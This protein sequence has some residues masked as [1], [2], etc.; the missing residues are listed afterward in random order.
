MF[1]PG[2]RLV[3]G[4]SGGADSV[5]LLY[6]LHTLARRWALRLVVAHLHHGIRGQAADDDAS[7]VQQL[8][9]RLGLPC[10]VEYADVPSRSR[11]ARESI[12]MAARAERRAFFARVCGAY[13]AEAVALAHTADDAAETLLL[14]LLRGS[15]LAGLGGLAAESRVGPVRVVR[16]LIDV[17]RA[18]V[19][20]FLRAHNLQWREDATN[21]DLTIPRNRVRHELVP[22]LERQYQPNIRRVLARTAEAMRSDAA[23]LEPMI[24]R[25]FARAARSDG[26]MSRVAL[27]RMPTA[28]RRHV[29][30]RWL[31]ARGVPEPRLD[32]RALARVESLIGAGRGQ[33]DVASGLVARVRGDGL[34]LEPRAHR[35]V[36]PRCES[37][38]LPG[39]VRWDEEGLVLRA[40]PW[41]GIVRAPAGPIGRP[42]AEASIRVPRTG[43]R[44][45]VRTPWPG[46]RIEPIGM[47]GSVKLQDLFVNDRVPRE[48]RAA[49]PV[50]ACGD[51]VVWVPGHRVSRAWAVP[52]EIAPSIRLRLLR[53]KAAPDEAAGGS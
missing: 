5:A 38:T 14:R 33:S 15:G 28:L 35:V 21:R 23:L 47:R 19:E 39:A 37:L 18:E 16:P 32:A 10:V 29:L 34:V 41:T 30:L 45:E 3:V 6:A 1:D 26:A 51:E 49:I 52:S 24:H 9:W 22:L 36:L 27:G 46:A 31:R 20:G 12:E 7:F 44:L 11:R 4:V 13:G 42:P 2:A 50:V 8:A 48:E 43:E 53:E 40:D 17:T 25:A